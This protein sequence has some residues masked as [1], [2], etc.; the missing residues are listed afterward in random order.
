MF[1]NKNMKQ[2]AAQKK[3]LV[4]ELN[5]KIKALQAQLKI[6]NALE[7]ID[8]NIEVK[9]S[10]NQARFKK[11]KQKDKEDKAYGIFLLEIKIAAEQQDVFV[12]ISIASGK[13]VTGFMYQ[14]EGTAPGSIVTTDIKV[15]GDGVS[16]V[17]LGTLLYAKIPAGKTA[18]FQI[19]TTIQGK[20]K[21]QYKI[22]ITRLN[23]KL[24]LTDTR[25]KQ[26]LKEI[27]SDNVFL[28]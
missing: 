24:S 11:I 14:I 25:Y 13:R 16:Q 5:A 23:Y 4:K 7:G 28:S 9:I 1:Y 19:Q 17:T 22:V 8:P 18:S 2:T 3:K 6:A 10:K 27:H 21:K 15:R 26:Y 12:P 20:F